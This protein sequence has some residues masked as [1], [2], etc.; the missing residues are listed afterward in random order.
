MKITILTSGTRGDVQ[1]Y[2]ALGRALQTRGHDVL[3][4]CPD[5]FA[6][7]VEEHWLEFHT[8]PTKTF[9]GQAADVCVLITNI[10]EAE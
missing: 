2:I 7:W 8:I 9:W 4:A 6:S 3:L 10:K 5:N 1:P